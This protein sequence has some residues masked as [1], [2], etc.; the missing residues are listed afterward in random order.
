[1]RQEIA[2]RH[3]LENGNPA[4]GSTIGTG[5]SIE[6]QNGPLGRGDEKAEPNGAF[7]E[8][9]IGSALDRVRW[10]QSVCGGKFACL[11]NERTIT[12][13]EQA[14]QWCDRRTTDREEREV[15]GTHTE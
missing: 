8:G 11:E 6:W 4:G 2:S 12:K 9:V 5:I 14:L 7:V 13:L 10:Y 15:E 1:M 3:D